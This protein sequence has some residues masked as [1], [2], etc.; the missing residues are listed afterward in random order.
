MNLYFVDHDTEHYE[1]LN[2][3]PADGNEW[4]NFTQFA[5]L[6]ESA[7]SQWRPLRFRSLDPLREGYPGQ[8]PNGDFVG[9]GRWF[10]SLG[11]RA[12]DAVGGLMSA[13]GELLPVEHIG[14]RETLHWFHC[15]TVIDA[16]DESR[17][18]MKRFADGK[19]MS[20][21]RLWVHPEKLRDAML[22][23]IPQNGS[24]LLCTDTF[25]QQIEALGLTGLKFKL[26]WSDEPAG[27]KQISDWEQRA[28]FDMPPFPMPTA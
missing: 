18:V 6:G 8:L 20:V 24:F 10:F 26:K 9:L 27:M 11:K 12:M 22:F 2:S 25:K 19:V 28:L 14:R 4:L 3:V 16:M 23:H 17:S 15:T 13:H 21:Q 7:A 5:S 1:W